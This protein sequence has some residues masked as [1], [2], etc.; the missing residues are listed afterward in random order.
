MTERH[1]RTDDINDAPLLPERIARSL[2]NAP[3]AQLVARSQAERWLVLPE[4]ASLHT[5][6]E[7]LSIDGLGPAAIRKLE[8]WLGQHGRRLRHSAE[9]LDTVICNF[10]FY[11]N[12]RRRRKQGARATHFA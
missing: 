5:R 6:Q 11:A 4:I 9:S 7:L 10:G 1:H 12:Q 3:H 2:A 8:Q